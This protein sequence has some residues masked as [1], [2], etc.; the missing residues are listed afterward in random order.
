MLAD[1]LSCREQDTG[2]QK[3]L[4]KAHRTQVLF[5]PDKLDPEITRRLFTK[6][7]PVL[8]TF[9]NFPEAFVVLTNSHVPLDL[10]NHILTAN[11][12]SPSLEDKRAKAIRGDQDWNIQDTCLLYKGRL[13]IPEDNNL[14]TKLLRFI[15]VVLDA[16]HPGKT[17]TL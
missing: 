3:A 15:Y 10:I 6:L 13:V 8:E 2:C 12:Q 11:K 16:A 1:T 14:C 9:I 17:K 7:A 4:E 5:T